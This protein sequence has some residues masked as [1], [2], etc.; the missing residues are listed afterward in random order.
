VKPR[1]VIYT[2]GACSPNPGVGGWAAV[3][4]PQ[5]DRRREIWGAEPKSTNQ[6]MELVGAIEALRAL[7]GPYD[8]LLHTDSTYVCNGFVRGW[9]AT[10]QAN[11][12]RNSAKKPVVNKDL[13]LE[14]AALTT[15]HHVDWKWV[16]GHAGVEE[17]ERCDKLAVAARERLR[18]KLTHGAT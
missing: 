13:W 18:L 11:G 10:W 5:G 14:L 4:L 15:L 16:P 12:W 9:V 8:V 17:N 6:R 2:D 7:E 1:V 3:L